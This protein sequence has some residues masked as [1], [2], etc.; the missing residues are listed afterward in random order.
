MSVKIIAFVLIGAAVV[1][2]VAVPVMW[3]AAPHTIDSVQIMDCAIRQTP[4][5]MDVVR[6]TSPPEAYVRYLVVRD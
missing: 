6:Y 3:Y 5:G 2:T 1:G 4:A